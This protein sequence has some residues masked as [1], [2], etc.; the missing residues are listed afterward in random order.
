MFLVSL[1]T[2]SGTQKSNTYSS[3]DHTFLGK[4]DRVDIFQ[5]SQHVIQLRETRSRGVVFVQKHRITVLLEDFVLAHAPGVPACCPMRGSPP[6]CTGVVSCWAVITMV[7][8]SMSSQVGLEKA[9]RGR[10]ILCISRSYT[11]CSRCFFRSRALNTNTKH[12]FSYKFQI[13]TEWPF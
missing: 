2:A 10:V 7:F 5:Y 12:R 3:C 11:R 1:G 13:S 8:S 9:D 6:S 4:Q